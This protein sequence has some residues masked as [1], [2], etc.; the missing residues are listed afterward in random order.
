M[1]GQC[2]PNGHLEALVPIQRPPA[3]RTRWR[4]QGGNGKPMP[5]VGLPPAFPPSLC[6]TFISY[7]YMH[8]LSARPTVSR[9]ACLSAHHIEDRGRE[10]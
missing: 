6:P 3:G 9:A 10:Y 1:E 8:A 5:K 2:K 7:A 4:Q